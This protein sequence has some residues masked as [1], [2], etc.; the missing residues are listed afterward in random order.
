M[1]RRFIPGALAAAALLLSLGAAALAQESSNPPLP[2]IDWS[3]DGPFGSF[4]QAALRRGFQV[5]SQVCSACHSMNLLSYRDLEGPGGLGYSESEAAAIAAQKQVTDG[6]NDQG[7]MFQRP[8]RTADGFAAPFPNDKAARAANNGALPPDLSDIVKARAG[9]ADYVHALLTGF[10][11][12]PP[13]FVLA[14][15]MNYNLY[16]PGN[17]IAMPQPLYENQI[18]YDDGTK[19]PLDQEARD[20]AT[21]LAWASDPNMEQRKRIGVRVILFLLVVTGLLYA[22][23]RRIWSGLGKKDDNA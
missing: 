2:K 8:A 23:Q 15:G 16:F 17:Q 9:G 13:G 4:D 1:T 18:A 14:A 11:D 20:V 21:F 19:A 12:P 22:V 6:P 10:H 3:F 7:Q 5:Y